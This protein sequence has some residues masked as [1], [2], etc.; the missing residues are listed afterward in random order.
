MRISKTIFSKKKMLI[1]YSDLNKFPLEI[2]LIIKRI[3]TI[4]DSIQD[5]NGEHVRTMTKKE[6]IEVLRNWT[7]GDAIHKITTELTEKDAEGEP[8]YSEA[9]QKMYLDWVQQN[10]RSLCSFWKYGYQLFAMEDC[11]EDM[12]Y[13]IAY[14][15][16]TG[17][18][19]P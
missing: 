3:A 15:V 17:I 18:L 16:K 9:E 7:C 13:I 2:S 10:K 11:E 4:G 19:F 5:E 1:G 12:Y 6:Y 14:F 8:R